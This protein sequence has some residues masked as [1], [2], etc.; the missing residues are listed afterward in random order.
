MGLFYSGVSVERQRSGFVLRQ[1]IFYISVKEK[2]SQVHQ[3]DAKHK[4]FHNHIH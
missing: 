1:I 2:E 3:H 4:L